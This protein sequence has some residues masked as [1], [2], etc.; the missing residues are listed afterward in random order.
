[1][2]PRFWKIA[3]LAEGFIL[4]ALVVV[5]I[6]A[7][8][9]FRGMRYHFFDRACYFGD[10]DGVEMLLKLGADPDGNRD[11]SQYVKYVAA[12]EPTAPIF[13][14]AWTGDTNVMSLL[15]A[16]HANPNIVNGEG[17]L[18][19][20]AVAVIHGHAE[21]AHL[22]RAAG[23]RLDLPDGRSIMDLADQHGYTNIAAEL[24]QSK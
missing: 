19:P 17:D 4:I 9:I 24:Q 23:A 7:Y 6:W 5:V 12:I 21:A 8:P 15:L 20:L 3:A 14:A 22:L 16:A 10:D 18:T 2:K 13:Q 11:Y 1:V